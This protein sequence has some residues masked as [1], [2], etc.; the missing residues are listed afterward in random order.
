MIL[1]LFR[2]AILSKIPPIME[3]EDND[4]APNSVLVDEKL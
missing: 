1:E 3:Y 2:P 4:N